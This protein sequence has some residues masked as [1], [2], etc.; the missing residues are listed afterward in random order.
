MQYNQITVEI[1]RTHNLGNYSNI[2][3]TV[4]SIVALSEDDP[5]EQAIE[6]AR[7][8]AEAQIDA[9][10]CQAMRGDDDVAF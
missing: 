2:K 9:A 8:L 7:L 1:S 10:I 5:P 6:E 3:P 4:S